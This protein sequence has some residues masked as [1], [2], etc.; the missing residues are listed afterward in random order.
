M[1]N[2]YC[3]ISKG[4][5]V[6]SID[7]T[8]SLV[9]KLTR[10]DNT[11][12]GHIYLYSV[13]ISFKNTTIPVHQMLSETH[14]TEFIAYWLQQWIRR[15]ARKPREAVCDYSRVMISAVCMAM[16]NVTIKFYI[17]E[18]FARIKGIRQPSISLSTFIRLDVA[19]LIHM[20][21]R[22]KS[23]KHVKHTAIKDFFIRCVALMVECQ[24]LSQL[25]EIFSL[26]CVVG[27]QEYE[28]SVIGFPQ[29]KTMTRGAR[30]R[31]EGYIAARSTYIVFEERDSDGSEDPSVDDSQDSPRMSSPIEQWVQDH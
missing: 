2:E 7:A 3:R 11:K 15:G 6:I 9:T 25:D 31:L 30:K 1:Y 4:A 8:G 16:N 28:D 19:H 22:W 21:C 5:V 20:V 27:M 14:E 18:L 17:N 26:T 10:P 23:L 13:V 24:T 12:T 29:A